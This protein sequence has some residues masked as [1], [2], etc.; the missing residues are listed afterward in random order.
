MA[1]R[2]NGVN[3]LKQKR[4]KS[5]ITLNKILFMFVK[6]FSFLGW[7]SVLLLLVLDCWLTKRKSEFNMGTE[8]Y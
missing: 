7:E 6:T 3:V 5:D 4:E 2:K 8:L 1:S